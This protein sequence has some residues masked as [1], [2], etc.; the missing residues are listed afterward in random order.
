MLSCLRPQLL[1]Q[2]T[3]LHESRHFVRD[4]VSTFSEGRNSTQACEQSMVQPRRILPA[5]PQA[6]TLQPTTAYDALHF[7]RSFS[8]NACIRMTTTPTTCNLCTTDI[9]V[10]HNPQLL[11]R[12]FFKRRVNPPFEGHCTIP[13]AR[14]KCQLRDASCTRKKFLFLKHTRLPPLAIEGRVHEAGI[15]TMT[16]C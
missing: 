15:D 3:S 2:G 16:M 8:R 9:T 4:C 5:L 6:E 11:R 1:L 10:L 14:T 12:H 13:E 7:N